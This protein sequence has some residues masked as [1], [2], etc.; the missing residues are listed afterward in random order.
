MERVYQGVQPYPVQPPS[1]WVTYRPPTVA[2]SGS[3]HWMTPPLDY[4]SLDVLVCADSGGLLTQPHSPQVALRLQ[5]TRS[6]TTGVT[7]GSEGQ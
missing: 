4:P 5:T 2:P 7:G 3:S 1:S 6:L